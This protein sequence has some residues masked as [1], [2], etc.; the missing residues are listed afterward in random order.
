VQELYEV[1]TELENEIEC[2]FFL[3]STLAMY[4]QNVYYPFQDVK[5]KLGDLQKH[6]EEMEK[7]KPRLKDFYE[8]QINSLKKYCRWE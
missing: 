5:V 8:N 6:A 3:K 7:L 2:L 4:T 1:E